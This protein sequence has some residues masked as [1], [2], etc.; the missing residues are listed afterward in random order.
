MKRLQCAAVDATTATGRAVAVRA[1]GGDVAHGLP[2]LRLYTAEGDSG[3][4][5][6]TLHVMD[7]TEVNDKLISLIS[8][9]KR[10]KR[11]VA[12]L[13]K[14]ANGVFLKRP[15]EYRTCEAR[16]EKLNIKGYG[17]TVERAMCSKQIWPLLEK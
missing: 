12:G 16:E 1:L 10:I 14:D 8:L 9:K 4:G 2:A 11:G 3:Q 7:G 5:K 13:A 15:D 6:G 17:M